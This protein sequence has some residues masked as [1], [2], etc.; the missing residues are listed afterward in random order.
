MGATEATVMLQPLKAR[1]MHLEISQLG[2][3]TGTDVAPPILPPGG[4][5][6][7][8][9]GCYGSPDPCIPEGGTHMDGS[10]VFGDHCI[11]RTGYVC[12]DTGR[13]GECAPMSEDGFPNCVNEAA[14]GKCKE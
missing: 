2:E 11:C 9:G 4:S 5:G 3:K 7:L 13:D 12:S 8:S 1:D 10:C 14:G 6:E